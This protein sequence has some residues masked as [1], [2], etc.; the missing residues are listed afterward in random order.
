[1]SIYFTDSTKRN[2]DTK[3]IE[4]MEISEENEMLSVYTC[5]YPYN[6]EIST[7]DSII[8]G[9][10]I[11]NLYETVTIGEQVW[12][13]YN[14]DVCHYRNGDPILH[15]QTKEEWESA[16]AQGTGVWCYYDNDPENGKI[17]GKLYNWYAVNDERGIAPEG[18][19]VPNDD[20]WVELTTLLGDAAGAKLSGSYDLWEEGDLRNH[21][22]FNSTGFA[23][24]PGGYR[25][26]MGPSSV[27]IRITSS[28]WTSSEYSQLFASFWYIFYD[29]ENLD[30]YENFKRYGLAVR[31]IRE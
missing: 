26:Y 8:F 17:Y 3:S 13:Q 5:G 27:G 28:W 11:D 21:K 25:F 12:M 14:L 19:K 6:Y 2:F 1:M 30:R 31:C 18:W 4:K 23:G 7:I 15:A 22:D 20:N 16:G 24:L 10:E 9:Y 29:S